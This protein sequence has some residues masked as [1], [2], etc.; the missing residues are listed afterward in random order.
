[1]AGFHVL[2]IV[3]V[4]VNPTHVGGVLRSTNDGA[5]SIPAVYT[6]QNIMGRFCMKIFWGIVLGILLAVCAFAITVAICALVHKIGFFDQ[7]INWAEY[8]NGLVKPATTVGA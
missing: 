1:M 6:N 2:L 4:G 3:Y 8:F 7:I 5:G